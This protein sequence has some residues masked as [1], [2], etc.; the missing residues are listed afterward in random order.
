MVRE[1]KIKILHIIPTL[2]TGGAERLLVDIAKRI[3]HDS[4]ECVV[5]C[6]KRGGIWEKELRAAGVK[7]IVLAKRHKIDFKNISDLKQAIIS[8]SPDIV[9]THLGGD[10]Y[11]RWLAG[12]LGIPV[13]STEHN[14]NTDEGIITRLLKRCTAP[15]AKKIIAVSAA[16]AA[17]AQKRYGISRDKLSIIHNGVDVDRFSFHQPL[18]NRPVH[19]GAVGRLTAQ[20]DFPTLINAM[21]GLKDKAVC[22]IVGAGPDELFLQDIIK[23][24]D[25]TQTVHLKGVTADIPAFLKG[26]D[27]FVLP[28]R[29]EGL[30]I[31]IL[32]AALTGVPVIAS[33]VDGIAEIIDDQQNGLLFTA[34]NAEELAEKIEDVI[35]N[36]PQALIRADRLRQKVT[37]HFSIDLMI[38]RYEKLYQEI[39]AS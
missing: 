18:F 10:I 19:I 16:V 28:S 26:L 17:D 15:Y 24:K 38:S 36:Q 30:G 8:E 25:L 32:E 12:R 2:D 21:A 14:I 27:I 29:W 9:H 39:T 22:D 20:K 11:G 34:G 4:F 37:T 6:F 23:Q 13:V 31:V 1:K 35:A 33:R 3:H 5:V 7:V